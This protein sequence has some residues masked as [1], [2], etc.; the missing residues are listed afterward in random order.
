M[1]DTIESDPVDPIDA[2]ERRRRR[3]WPLWAGLAVVAAVGTVGIVSVVARD[4][5]QDSDGPGDEAATLPT[6]PPSEDSEDS[7]ASDDSG[8]AGDVDD[9][10]TSPDA[11]DDEAN[12]PSSSP[13][14]DEPTPPATDLPAPPPTVPLGPD[15]ADEYLDRTSLIARLDDGVDAP[16]EIRVG[17]RPYGDFFDV[18]WTSPTG[19]RADCLSGHAVL[20]GSPD[21]P[22]VHSLGWGVASRWQ[23]FH[24]SEPT[25]A[26]VSIWRGW[27]MGAERELLLVRAGADVVEVA[28]PGMDPIVPSEGWGATLVA[29]MWEGE[30]DVTPMVV[31]LADGSTF[32]VDPYGPSPAYPE[33]GDPCGPPAYPGSELPAAGDPPPDPAAAEQEIRERH[34]LLV[35]QDQPGDDKLIDLL[36]DA[37]GV[38]EALDGALNG[39]LADAARSAEYTIDELIFT[40][41]AEAFFRYTIQ[42]SSGTFSGRLGAA[43]LSDDGTWRISRATL[44]QDL[45]LAGSPCSGG[46]EANEVLAVPRDEW[47]RMLRLFDQHSQAWWESTAC[48]P[49]V[50][51]WAPRLPEPGGDKPDVPDAASAEIVAAMTALYDDEVPMS[52]ELDLVDDPTGVADAWEQVTGAFDFDA[53]GVGVAVGEV[54]FVSSSEAWF[55]YDLLSDSDLGFARFGHALL[56]EGRW[57]IDRD[58]ICEDLSFAGGSCGQWTPAVP[59]R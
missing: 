53:R 40:S 51:C 20:V 45:S 23:A 7:E 35:D 18:E 48:N 49:V 52:D 44:C 26:E 37:T 8:D 56:I 17:D 59:P 36:D 33:P 41:P 38:A 46:P 54:V 16:I 9:A 31:R 55:A 5:T 14:V 42:T 25:P 1:A 43:G 2:P 50:P 34:A 3:S 57:R 27:A 6:V 11:G 47:E 28:G 12:A 39:S 21:G 24:L 4:D 58:T 30:P 32:D 15:P 29:A 13:S 19:S 10:T 22:D